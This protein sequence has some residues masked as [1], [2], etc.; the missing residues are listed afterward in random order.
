M[1]KISNIISYKIVEDYHIWFVEYDDASV[2]RIRMLS[3]D[4]GKETVKEGDS[5]EKHESHTIK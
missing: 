3:P 4:N 2:G 5:Y 1:K